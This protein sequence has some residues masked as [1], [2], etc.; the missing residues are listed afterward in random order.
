MN[1]PPRLLCLGLFLLINPLTDTAALDL[2]DGQ[3]PVQSNLRAGAAK[4]DITPAETEGVWVTGHRRQVHGVRDPLRAGVL[5]LDDGETKA[6]I[7]TLDTIGA[8]EELV[9][10]VREQIEKETGIPAANI[11][12]TASHNHSAPGFVENLKW[13]AELI[14]KLVATAKKAAAELRPVS[15]G[16]GE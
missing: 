9:K 8:W 6:A 11:L 15:V 14:A 10:P 7:I 3:F 13:G 5:V 16:Y 1:F 12:I 4:V 2:A